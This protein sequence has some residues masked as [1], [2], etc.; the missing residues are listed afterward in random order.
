MTKHTH[1]QTHTH[2][3]ITQMAAREAVTSNDN[4]YLLRGKLTALDLLVRV[5]D[6]PLHHWE[7]CFCMSVCVFVCVWGGGGISRVYVYTQ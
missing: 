2:T 1:K 4:G 6:N 5:M 7:V 3:Q